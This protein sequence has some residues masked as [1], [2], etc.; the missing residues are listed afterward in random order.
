MKAFLS[1]FYDKQ[2]LAL[3]STS[4]YTRHL[5]LSCDCL[6]NSVEILSQIKDEMDLLIFILSL[7]LLSSSLT[8]FSFVSLLCNSLSLFFSH[9][10]KYSRFLSLPLSSSFFFFKSL[11]FLSACSLLSPFLPLPCGSSLNQAIQKEESMSLNRL[12]LLLKR[13][14]S[15]LK[16]ERF[17][18]VTDEHDSSTD[19]ILLPSPS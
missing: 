14:G 7:S 10:H 8:F 5:F 9:I 16:K 19:I 13:S 17:L 18:F 6:K 4:S 3:M 11:L 2:S 12:P 1:L 15:L